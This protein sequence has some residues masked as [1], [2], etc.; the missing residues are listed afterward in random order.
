MV[1]AVKNERLILDKKKRKRRA[2]IRSKSHGR[3][4]VVVDMTFPKYI[5]IL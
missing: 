3:L 5:T 4:K 1:E 2:A